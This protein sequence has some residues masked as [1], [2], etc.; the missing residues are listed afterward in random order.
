MLY[1]VGDLNGDGL[2]DLAIS[3]ANGLYLLFQDPTQPGQFGS[4]TRLID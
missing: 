2:P 3:C 1:A 4:V